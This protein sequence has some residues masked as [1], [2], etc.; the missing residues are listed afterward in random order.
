M[1]RVSSSPAD[2]S[3]MLY[4]SIRLKPGTLGQVRDNR[5]C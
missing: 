3:K 5:L 4:D 2:N 1:I